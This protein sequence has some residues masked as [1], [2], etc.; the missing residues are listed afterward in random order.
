M[1]GPPLARLIRQLDNDSF[2]EREKAS[3]E[4]EKLGKEAEDSMRKALADNP[5]VEV[6]VR[7]ERLLENIKPGAVAPSG[8]AGRGL[9]RCWRRWERARLTSCCAR[10][11]SPLWAASCPTRP[12]KPCAAWTALQRHEEMGRKRRK[13]NSPEPLVASNA[14]QCGPGRNRCRIFSERR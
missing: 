12:G 1:G 3:A 5:P 7:L 11:R 13:D 4:L 10:R 8:C 6:K 2:E 14:L 9:W